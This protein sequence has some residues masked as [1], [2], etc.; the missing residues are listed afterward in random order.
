[1]LSCK[2][3][4]YTQLGIRPEKWDAHTSGGFWDR[5]LSPNLRPRNNQQKLRTCQIAD[6]A[7][8]LVQRSFQKKK[9]NMWVTVI[10]IVIGALGIIPK[11]LVNRQLDL[12]IRGQVETIQTTALLR[13]LRILRRVLETW[14][15]LRKL[16]VTQTPKN[17]N[18]QAPVW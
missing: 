17:N 3:T 4:V 12:G 10:Q 13:S 18:Q 2:Q 8:P 6:I 5:N 7:V 14:W 16:A 15:Y 1:M 9:C 11:Y